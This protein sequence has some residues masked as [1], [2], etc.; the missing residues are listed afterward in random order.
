MYEV[1]PDPILEGNSGQIQVRWKNHVHLTVMVFTYSEDFT[2]DRDD[3]AWLDGV[4]MTSDGDSDSLWIPV[5]T[6][7]DDKPERDETFSIGYWGGGS[8]TAA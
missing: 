1:C 7:E 8:G 5:T 2:A 3:Y 6:K 4:W